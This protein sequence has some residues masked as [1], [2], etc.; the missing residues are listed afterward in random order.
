[1]SSFEGA[2]S[3]YGKAKLEIERTV[4]DKGG[5]VIRPG[6]VYGKNPGGMMG[7]LNRL[8]TKS[9]ILPV[10]GRGKQLLYL[11]HEDD[12]A[13][14]VL[15]CGFSLEPLG[16]PISAA[17][18]EPL[19]FRDILRIMARSRGRAILIIPI[20]WI[21]PYATLK[22]AE[23]IGLDVGFRSDSLISVLNQNPVPDF[24]LP[25]ELK[26]S[27]RKFDVNSINHPVD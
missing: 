8:V 23:A 22:S 6:L 4:L 14:L 21:L 2:L 3:L 25:Q 10:L 7:A 11:V 26:V 17:Y 5:F 18:S 16:R 24:T 15:R 13:N 12:L 9:P 1:M 20:P 19:T 27:F